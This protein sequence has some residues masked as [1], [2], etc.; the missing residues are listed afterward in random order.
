MTLLGYGEEIRRIRAGKYMEFDMPSQASTCRVNTITA[1]SN[2]EWLT[3]FHESDHDWLFVPRSVLCVEVGVDINTIPDD[4]HVYRMDTRVYPGHC[5]MVLERSASASFTFI[6]YA[7]CS[8]EKW[9]IVL[10][11]DLFLDE[12]SNLTSEGGV[13]LE[14]A[15]PALSRAGGTGINID[16]VW[17][18]RCHCPVIL[19]RWAQ[20]PRLW[21]PQ[22]VVDKVVSLGSVVTTVGFKGSINRYLEWRICF[23]MGEVEL[24]NTL[25]IAQAKVFVILKMILKEVL[26]PQNKE[27]TSYVL[28]NVILWQ[29]ESN[30]PITFQ[31]RKLIHWFIDALETPRNAISSAQL[32]YYMIPERNLIAACGLQDE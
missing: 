31:E 20:R 28:K 14:R 13:P 30:T 2:A 12:M 1:G 6:N 32:P 21:P 9:N 10:S 25:N 26:K 15:G 3:S 23:N 4:I 11:S 24:V 18:V 22:D 5:M 7:L 8:D 29:A 16:G 19:Q 17:V 27:I